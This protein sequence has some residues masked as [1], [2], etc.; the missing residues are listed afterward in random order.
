MAPGLKV[1]GL[2]PED[3]LV[4]TGCEEVVVFGLLEAFSAA[5]ASL[6][7]WRGGSEPELALRPAA[8]RSAILI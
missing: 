8:D 1:S 6:K 3:I 7:V 4:I 5:K 2:L